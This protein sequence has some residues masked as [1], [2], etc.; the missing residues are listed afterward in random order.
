MLKKIQNVDLTNKRVLLRADFNVLLDKDKNVQDTYKIQ[1]VRETVDY[2]LSHGGATLALMSHMGRPSGVVDKELSLA[3][4]RDDISKILERPVNVACNSIGVC[5]QG[6]LEGAKQ[7][8]ILL[9]ENLRFHEQEKANDRHFAQQL[10]APFD[11]YINDAF[12]VCHRA[13]ASVE[14][15]TE[16]IPHYAGLWLQKEVETL[17]KVRDTVEAPA[18][19]IIGGAKIDTKIP[20]ITALGKNYGTILVGG[21]TSV[22]AV[23][24]DM[25]F[26]DK[27]IL[28]IDF[29]GSERYDIGPETIVKFIEKITTAKTVVW[30]GPLGKF[31]EKPYDTSTVKIAQAIAENKDCFSVVGGG[32]SVQALEAAGLTEKISFISTGGG[33][34]LAFLA[35]EEMPGLRVLIKSP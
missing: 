7:G 8:E 24:A 1:A 4:I 14:A 13:H 20:L 6:A 30:N 34:M 11:S 23:D 17:T 22:E 21:R 5:V 19:A 2:V 15:I 28:P 18:V 9:L 33:A 12:S 32:E 25:E 10:A 35:G 26:D 27:V 29:T 16:H 31:E 3:H